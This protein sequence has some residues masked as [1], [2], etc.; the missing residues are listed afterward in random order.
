MDLLGIPRGVDFNMPEILPPPLKPSPGQ[1]PLAQDEI[2]PHGTMLELLRQ[3]FSAA[4]DK[5]MYDRLG[6]SGHWDVGEEW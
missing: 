4:Y 2:L 5:V 1:R 3:G 6:T